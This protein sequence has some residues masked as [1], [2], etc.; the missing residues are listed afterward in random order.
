MLEKS[1]HYRYRTY[2]NFAKAVQAGD[3]TWEAVEA[4]TETLTKD[5]AFARSCMDKW[6]FQ[7]IPRSKLLLADGSATATQCRRA[8]RLDRQASSFLANHVNHTNKRS[9]PME[10]SARNVYEDVSLLDDAKEA[11]PSTPVPT[12][13]KRQYTKRIG[14]PASNVKHNKRTVLD[15][16]AFLKQVKKQ[17]L[18]LAQKE[19]GIQ[20][21]D[22]T[23]RAT[24]SAKKSA[25]K[26]ST[27]VDSISLVND[28]G[29][30]SRSATLDN[31]PETTKKRVLSEEPDAMPQAKRRRLH[32][33]QEHLF[34][35]QV[36]ERASAIE[37][38]LL[39]LSRPG[40]YIMPPGARP[41]AIGRPRNLLIVV[42][43]SGGLQE[44]EWFLEASSD[45]PNI[46][47]DTPPDPPKPVRVAHNG[48][49]LEEEE[50]R[51]VSD[52][53]M[54]FANSSRHESPLPD[55]SHPPMPTEQTMPAVTPA[56]FTAA[57]ATSATFE[58]ATLTESP[59]ERP[60]KRQRRL[61][62]RFEPEDSGDVDLTLS[63]IHI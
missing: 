39:T 55:A 52:P 27:Q 13:F 7:E 42:I 18:R 30:S 33:A 6:G 9:R 36:P 63:L 22:A 3:T 17:A 37:R 21:N 23:S 60:A 32:S 35:T 38:E 29:N 4:D 40:M 48:H 24:K 53:S 43:K 25:R 34:A 28:T 57:S 59:L 14:T 41:P 16:Q 62:R 19:L 26:S 49:A 20:G 46:V 54:P 10:S 5:Q 45:V 15:A 50:V 58:E 1:L 8:F 12:H 47:R 44:K 11:N 51:F 31:Q 56:S 2:G 61:P